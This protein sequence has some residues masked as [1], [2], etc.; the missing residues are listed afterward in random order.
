ID[1]FRVDDHPSQI[2]A[3]VGA[4]PCPDEISAETFQALPKVEQG[5]LWCCVRA[6]RDAGLW[7]R[8]SE[9]RIGL[10]LGNAAEWNSHWEIDYLRGGR[11]VFETQEHIDPI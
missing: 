7:E 8:R 6:L 11:A 9:L 4:I 2:G 10:V 5:T 1:L 3:A